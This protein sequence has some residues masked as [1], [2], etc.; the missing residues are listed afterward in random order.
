MSA[1]LPCVTS[2]VGGLPESV[3]DGLTGYCHG[4]NDVMAMT[5]SLQK[6]LQDETLALRM[7]E[8]GRKR[9]QD[10]F[11]PDRQHKK[12]REWYLELVNRAPNKN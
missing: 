9:V 2:N 5:K 4:P 6:L 11:G 12:L 7:G 3:L 1:G 8:A 10:L